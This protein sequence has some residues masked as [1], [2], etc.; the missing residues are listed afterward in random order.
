MAQHTGSGSQAAVKIGS[1]LV[2]DRQPCYVIAEIGINH[3]GDIDQAKRLISVAVAAGC[4]AVKF[5]KRTIEVVYSAEELVKPRENPFG[6]TNG[7]L[8]RGLELDFYDY[9]EIDAFCRASKITWFASCWDEGSVDFID[10][11]SPPCYKIASASLTD[12]NLLRHTR[13]K[14]KPII[15][16]TGMSTIDQI[17]HAV[18]V[19]GKDDLMLL[20]ACSTYPAYY[21]ELNLRAIPSMRERYGVPVG[22]SGHETGI[23]STIAAA[24][25]GA[26]C[27]ERHITLDRSMWGS[28]HAASLEPNG[29]SRIVRDV[30]LVEQSMGDGVKRVYEREQPIIKKLRRVDVS[31]T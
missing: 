7:D 27:I 18:E 25:L 23:A 12:D 28:D 17:D 2:G 5:Q 15:L 20:H 24:V 29:I 11:F 8:K 22:Y 31:T 21:E 26:C 9:Q 1:R 4:D 30:R 19:L 14:G 3:N 6:T 16:S 10:R 13:A